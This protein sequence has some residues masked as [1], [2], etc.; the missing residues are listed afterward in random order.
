MAKNKR[1]T[2][3]DV[4]RLPQRSQLEVQAQLGHAVKRASGSPM[5]DA[6]DQIQ[7]AHDLASGA[8][9]HTYGTKKKRLRQ[10][11]KPVL[12]ALETRFLAKLKREFEIISAKPEFKH[13]FWPEMGKIFAQA[14]RLE[15]ARGL[16][17]KPDFFLPRGRL[18]RGQLLPVAYE[19]KGEKVFRGGFE[20]LKS[21]ARV[22]PWI[23]FWL[24]WED[25]SGVWQ[26]QEVLP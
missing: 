20:N 4:A 2:L 13:E 9:T 18:S 14:V 19:V 7:Y 22:H 10:D 25:E 26:R 12:N 23:Q 16:W 24:V 3:A 21:A 5:M 8:I 1:F 6:V 11:T 15:L 17:Y